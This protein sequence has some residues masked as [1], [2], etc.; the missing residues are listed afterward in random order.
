VEDEETDGGE[1]AVESGEVEGGVPR[2]VGV[3]QGLG[4]VFKDAG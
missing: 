1:V 3:V 4:V 2:G